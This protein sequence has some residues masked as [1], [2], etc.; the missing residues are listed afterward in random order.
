MLINIWMNT[1][2]DPN[3]ETI[4]ILRFSIVEKL[5]LSCLVEAYLIINVWLIIV[6][7]KNVR[8]IQVSEK[9]ASLFRIPTLRLLSVET[10][11]ILVT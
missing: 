5:I 8:N 11:L 7:T 2:I 6:V 3:D 1:D 10:I 4:P 9:N